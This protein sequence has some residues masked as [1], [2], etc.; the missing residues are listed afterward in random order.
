MADHFPSDFSR[1]FQ[2]RELTHSATSILPAS[3]YSLDCILTILPLN[4][5][6]LADLALAQCAI[7]NRE[8]MELPKP[9]A[10]FC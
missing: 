3:H 4:L 9:G 6:I 8:Q 1:N 7:V 10:I 2:I 5:E